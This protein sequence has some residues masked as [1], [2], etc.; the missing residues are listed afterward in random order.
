MMSGFLPISSRPF[1]PCGR[2]RRGAGAGAGAGAA[3]RAFTLVEILA[4]VVILGIAAAVVIPQLG[5]RGDLK[6]KAGARMVVADLLYAQ[7]MAIAT[8]KW[9]Y[10]RFDR[11]GDSYSIHDAA[12]TTATTALITHP[13]TKE[14]YVVTLGGTTSR[15]A[16]IL[17]HDTETKFDG[18]DALFADRDTM[19]FDE[20]G[21]PH[22]YHPG[23][24]PS[25]TDPLQS[26]KVVITC[27]QHR[28]TVSVER[29]T[30]EISVN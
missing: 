17:I 19:A 27:G 2:R 14:N 12:P 20:L 6:A 23:G 24:S 1:L 9:H 28:V 25:K 7:N 5:D 13:L 16:G 4:V 15:T 8:Q 30:G 18:V 3:A 26:G 11:A 22:V 21:Q 10:V 29:F